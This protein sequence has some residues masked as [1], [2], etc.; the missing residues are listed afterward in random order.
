M[1]RRLALAFGSCKKEFSEEGATGSLVTKITFEQTAT[2]AKSTAVPETSWKSIKQIQMFLYDKTTGV[3]KFSDVIQPAASGSLTQTWPMIPVGEYELV[4][5]AN[6]KSSSDSVQTSLVAS[7]NPA[8]EWTAMNVR[9]L[10]SKDLGIYHMPRPGGFPAAINTVLPSS[11]GLSA[12]VAPSEIFMAEASTIVKIETGKK[13][14]LATPLELKREVAL[15]RVRLKTN[16]KSQGYDNSKVDFARDG[17]SIMIY[18]LPEKIGIRKGQEGGVSTTSN[19]KAVL[20]AASGKETFFTKDPTSGYS[21]GGTIVDTDFSL[22][23]DVVVFPNDGGRAKNS[24]KPNT[25]VDAPVAQRYYVVVTGFAPEN[26]LLS[27]NTTVP[28]GGAVIYWGGLV[29]AA[30]EPNTIREVNL[31]LTS[32]GTTGVP[33]EPAKEGGLEINVS[34]PTPWDSNIKVSNLD[35]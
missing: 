35:V 7:G 21:T 13:E 16:D 17:A 19:D 31:T 32:G 20:V 18:T 4:L 3:I 11:H 22:W 1:P 14:V 2:R 29:E 8:T 10:A 34:A 24:P 25:N 30:F 5:V 12:H 6:V 9:S 28:K 26:H 23:R 33:T 15:M 27:N